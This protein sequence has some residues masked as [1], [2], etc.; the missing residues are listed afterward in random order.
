[1]NQFKIPADIGTL[2]SAL[3]PVSQFSRL[4]ESSKGLLPLL[5]EFKRMNI[6]PS[7][8]SYY[9]ILSYFNQKKKSDL[10]DAMKTI[11]NELEGKELEI[12]HESDVLFFPY[13]MGRCYHLKN[14]DLAGRLNGIL[15]TG[16]NYNFLADGLNENN[17]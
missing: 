12:R 5:V 15:F 17:Y 4:I 8:G 13:A 16:Q 6:E 2:N 10:A 11:L 3:K 7:L 9:Y 1:M 14:V